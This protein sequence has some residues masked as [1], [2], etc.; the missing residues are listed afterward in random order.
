[1][2]KPLQD[3]VKEG[4]YTLV[5][6]GQRNSETHKSTTR[7]GHI[8]DGVEYWFPLENW[9]EG[10]VREF[11]D[12]RRVPLP[13]HYSWFNSSLDCATCTAYLAQNKGKLAW[14][15]HRHPALAQRLARKL[16]FVHSAAMNEILHIRETLGELDAA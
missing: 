10:A 16:H 7:S 2:W 13:E 12:E 6:R 4:G 15:Q 14:M 3:A 1:L 9:S 8:E 5:I 11:L